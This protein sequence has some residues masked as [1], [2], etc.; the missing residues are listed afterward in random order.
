MNQRSSFCVLF[1]LLYA[2]FARGT[3]IKD[4]ENTSITESHEIEQKKQKPTF[5]FL[6]KEGFISWIGARF[7]LDEKDVS[8]ARAL[9]LFIS[10]VYRF[11]Y[12]KEFNISDQTWYLL[13]CTSNLIIGGINGL[14]VNSG[15]FLVGLPFEKGINLYKGDSYKL[16]FIRSII[17]TFEFIGI[18]IAGTLLN[19]FC[20]FK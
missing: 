3:P 12:T 20:T 5:K 16:K 6:L 15:T 11:Y 19:H 13:F 14:I 17:I 4:T 8:L 7:D 10:Q 1:I 18:S 9:A 2:S